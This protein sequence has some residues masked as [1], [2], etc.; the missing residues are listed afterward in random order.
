MTALAILLGC[1]IGIAALAWT[2]DDGRNGS[3]LTSPTTVPIL[4]RVAA[5]ATAA[6][7]TPAT[8]TPARAASR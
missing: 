2:R 7:S 8:A 1:L 5:T 6:V 3:L 4:T